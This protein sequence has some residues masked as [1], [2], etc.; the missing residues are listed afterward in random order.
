MAP[1]DFP[2]SLPVCVCL[3]LASG[4]AQAGRLLVVPMDG[5]HWFTMQ[6]VVEKLIHRGHE[7]VVVMPEVSWQIGKSVNFTVKTYSTSYTLENLDQKF[8]YFSHTQWKTPEQSVLSLMTGSAKVFSKLMFSHCRSLFND[9][10][11]VEYLKQSSFDAVFLDPFEICGLTVAKYLS[12]PSLLFTRYFY[13]HYLEEGTQCPS[14][15]SYVP[16]LFSK[17]SDTMTFKERLSNFAFYMEERAFCHHLF[18]S[19]TDI[20]SEVLQ[21]PVTLEDLFSQA[22]IWLLRTDFVLDFPKPVMPNMVFIGGLNCQ[23]RKP[24][25]KVCC[26]SLAHEEGPGFRQ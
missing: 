20:A 2:A 7:L 18:K 4:F 5:S 12:V 13:C 19:A 8:K 1:A 10:K 15:L 6:L 24:L 11:L 22:S 14:P 17:L 3:L 23:K 9:K 16:R 21:T 26:L 25:S